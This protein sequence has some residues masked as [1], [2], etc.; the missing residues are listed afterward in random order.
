[1]TPIYNGILDG[2]SKKA[3][4]PLSPFVRGA[5]FGGA[6]GTAGGA[7]KTPKEGESRLLNALKY[8]V[9]G[10]LAAGSGYHIGH[11]IHSGKSMIPKLE[12]RPAVV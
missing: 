10:A 5:I 12:F 11:G 3:A 2:M 7:L 1:M 6:A 4:T 9:G 8:G